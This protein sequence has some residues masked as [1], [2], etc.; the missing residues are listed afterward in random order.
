M[1]FQ[2]WIWLK[3]RRGE[4]YIYEDMVSWFVPR[5]MIERC[6]GQ[7]VEKR[8]GLCKD[9]D[10]RICHVIEKDTGEKYCPILF[11]ELAEPKWKLKDVIK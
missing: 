4:P 10:G 3:S 9:C 6:H 1:A 8:L 5:A 7:F 11:V 2:Y